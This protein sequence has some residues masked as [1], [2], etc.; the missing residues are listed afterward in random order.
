M[1]LFPYEK[2]ITEKRKQINKGS[3]LLNSYLLTVLLSIPFK[4]LPDT[5]HNSANTT[6]KLQNSRELRLR[7]VKWKAFRRNLLI[8]K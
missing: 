3:N 8:N 4:K 2:C 6:I 5:N 7:T 1:E